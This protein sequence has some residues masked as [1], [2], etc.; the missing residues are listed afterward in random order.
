[1]GKVFVDMGVSL[2]GFVAGDNRG[3]KI[4]RAHV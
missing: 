3:P 4:G 1:M 2:D